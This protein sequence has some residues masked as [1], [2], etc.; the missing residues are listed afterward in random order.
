MNN[1]ANH[2]HYPDADDP[3]TESEIREALERAVKSRVFS[4]SRRLCR[5]LRYTVNS[6]LDGTKDEL[7]ETSIGV[8]VYDRKIS[9]ERSED[10]IVRTEARR[11][12]NKLKEYYEAEGRSDAVAFHYHVG[13]YVPVIVRQNTR[14]LVEEGPSGIDASQ[15]DMA[16][17]KG[18]VIAVLPLT[19]LSGSDLSARCAA[20]LTEE[21]K[22]G[23]THVDGITVVNMEGPFAFPP[24]H[25]DMMERAQ[26]HGVQ[27]VIG[28][29][30]WEECLR[31]RVTIRLVQPDGFTAWS[32]R[33]EAKTNGQDLQ[34]LTQNLASAH[35]S[36]LRP[37]ISATRR[38]GHPI[39][40]NTLAALPMLY[41]AESLLD[42]GTAASLPVACFKFKEIVRKLPDLARPFCGIANACSAAAL[43]GEAKPAVLI[44]QAKA[45][46][47]RAAQLDP[48]MSMTQ[49]SLAY[50]NMLK[51]NWTSAD[52]HFRNALTSGDHAFALRQYALY[53]TA[54]N[55]FDQAEHHIQR[56]E[57][58]D[59]F[60]GRQKLAHSVVLH[61]MR[62][63]GKLN[64]YLSERASAGSLPPEAL[65]LLAYAHIV[66]GQRDEG[67]RIA[68]SCRR[69]LCTQPGQMATLAELLALSGDE[70]QAQ[71][72][73]GMFNF[74]ATDSPISFYRQALLALALN[75]VEDAWGYLAK[76]LTDKEPGMIWLN[77]EPRLHSLR[78][79]Q[80]FAKIMDSLFANNEA[81]KTESSG[82]HEKCVFKAQ[83][84]SARI[85]DTE[86][87][88][89]L[90]NHRPTKR[91]RC[92]VNFKRTQSST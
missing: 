9:Y 45:A 49:A 47:E 41:E 50:V 40:A 1:K 63:T 76:A 5:F 89:F 64:Y 31:L 26:K 39:R 72:I 75:Q 18:I 88:R 43:H 15:D 70:A 22:H 79:D 24:Q 12:R 61:C 21:L 80:R 32:Q 54:L 68:L 84:R 82:V 71:Q 56:A 46:A 60:S 81:D 35:I 11:L 28:G 13:N 29:S 8:H 90:S 19:D 58:I 34:N 77:V 59:P 92:G 20:G 27:V 25:S 17:R 6:V 73:V 62:Q 52:E 78:E 36:R 38:L 85:L 30:V 69:H 87:N 55:R 83:L 86:A 74:F 4:A 33:F 16:A 37:E 66:E 65:L 67:K 91:R 2:M 57:R 14:H 53:F 7:K 10:S 23:W 3:I 42:E 51:W 44:Q 48:E